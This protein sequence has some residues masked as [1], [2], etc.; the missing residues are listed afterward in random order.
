MTRPFGAAFQMAL[1]CTGLSGTEAGG[2]LPAPLRMTLLRIIRLRC[3][4]LVS[5]LG[6]GF[7]VLRFAVFGLAARGTRFQAAGAPSGWAL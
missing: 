4:L 6:S 2:L 5:A 3:A 1:S 7:A